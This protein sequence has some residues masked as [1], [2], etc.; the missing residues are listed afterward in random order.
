MIARRPPEELEGSESQAISVSAYR[1]IRPGLAEADFLATPGL[2]DH[3][4]LQSTPVIEVAL[5][6]L[7]PISVHEAPSSEPSI[8]Q[9]FKS[10]PFWPLA[11]CVWIV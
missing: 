9:L 1:V 2:R 8:T 10:G 3:K 6:S 5:F 11:S 4:P 7:W